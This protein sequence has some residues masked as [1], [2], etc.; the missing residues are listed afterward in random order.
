MKTYLV[1]QFEAS[2]IQLLKHFQIHLFQRFDSLQ[3]LF[4]HRPQ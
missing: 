2:R 1:C 4:L 3:I